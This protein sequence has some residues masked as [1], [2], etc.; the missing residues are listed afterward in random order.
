MEF[1]NII[2]TRPGSIEKPGGEANAVLLLGEK[3]K[4]IHHVY[5]LGN[6]VHDN[7]NGW[8][9]NISVA[10]NCTN[11]YVQNNK[12][13]NNTNIGID[14]YGN[15]G[16]CN[17]LTMDQPRNCKCIDNTV[18]NCKS[19][20]AENAGNYI[21]GA[22]D[23][24]VKGNKT[25]K[26]HYGIEVGS[27]EWKSYYTK[28]NYVRNIKISENIMYNNLYCGL[29]IGGWSND[30]TTGTVYDC[31]VINND[32]SK[33][34]KKDEIIEIQNDI[35]NNKELLTRFMISKHT[36]IFYQIKNVINFEENSLFIIKTN[37]FKNWHP[38]MAK[39][40][41]AETIDEMLSGNGGDS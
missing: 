25:F 5:I 11:I 23:I 1:R 14:F 34:N 24:L 4:S 33:G 20:F 41:L 10:G 32:F 26:N 17:D 28:E 37:E 6:K 15:A 22:K 3:K 16:Y 30:K 18:Y 39:I 7:I 35:D 27:E 13:Y 40:D 12:V 36:D 9:E 29:R 38:A 2:T 8:S 19:S 31:K 21:D